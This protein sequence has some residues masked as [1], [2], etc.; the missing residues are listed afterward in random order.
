[1]AIV[2]L[3]YYFVIP[4]R[5]GTQKLKIRAKQTTGWL[6]GLSCMHH[7]HTQVTHTQGTG[8]RGER[9][10]EKVTCKIVN[11]NALPP[12]K[13]KRKQASKRQRLDPA[14]GAL[15]AGR[16]LRRRVRR[17][18]LAGVARPRGVVGLLQRLVRHLLHQGGDGGLPPRGRRGRTTA[19]TR[20][21]A[22]STGW[23]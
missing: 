1:M 2:L 6:D 14:Q 4:A 10:R 12:K 23:R 13:E 22:S 19:P 20:P 17:R 3:Y 9:E 18:R 5:R 8:I 15:A 16:R 7:T 21:W 11:P